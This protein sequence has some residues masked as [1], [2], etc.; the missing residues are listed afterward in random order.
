MSN[1]IIKIKW[2]TERKR[3]QSGKIPSSEENFGFFIVNMSF[4]NFELAALF[5]KC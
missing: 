5:P 2:K 3:I 1:F 4:Y